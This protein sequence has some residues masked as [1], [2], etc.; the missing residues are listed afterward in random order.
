[1]NNGFPQIVASVIGLISWQFLGGGG[2]KFSGLGSRKL[3]G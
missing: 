1:M 3:R 2:E